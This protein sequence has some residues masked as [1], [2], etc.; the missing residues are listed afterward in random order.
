MRGSYYIVWWWYL[1]RVVRGTGFAWSLPSHWVLGARASAWLESV[2]VLR[3]SLIREARHGEETPTLTVLV[4]DVAPYARGGKGLIICPTENEF[5]AA[6]RTLA[7]RPARSRRGP[8]SRRS[9]GGPWGSA[10]RPTAPAV[11]KAATAG[12]AARWLSAARRASEPRAGRWR[13]AATAAVGAPAR[14]T[15]I[16]RG[17]PPLR[18]ARRRTARCV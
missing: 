8:G 13:W 10:A 7:A 11:A 6:T 3:T 2:S 4:P 12:R 18:P 1:A 15:P 14:P 16:P 17:R 5:S 9:P